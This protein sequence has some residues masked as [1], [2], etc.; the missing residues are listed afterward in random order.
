MKEFLWYGHLQQMTLASEIH[1]D[2]K[3][4]MTSHLLKASELWNLWSV[5]F[6]YLPCDSYFCH[7][8]VNCLSPD[9]GASL[10]I[11]LQCF[12]DRVW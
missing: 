10:L 7:F 9:E 4:A 3:Y 11:N 2:V 12:L 1:F 8:L 6:V 5:A